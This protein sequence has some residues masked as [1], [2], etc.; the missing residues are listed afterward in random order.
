MEIKQNLV[1][2]GK[3]SIKCPYERTP[4]FYVVHNTYN[5]APAK[6]EVSYM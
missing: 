4:Q 3:C 6:N 5:D 1:N 2:S